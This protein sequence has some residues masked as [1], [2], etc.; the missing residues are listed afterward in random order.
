MITVTKPRYYDSFRCLAS[1]CP[2]S[3]C[4][5]WAVAVDP[6]A[7]AL[8][9]SLPGALG[10]ALRRYLKEEDGDTV[11]SLR[12]DG[13][14][15]MWRDDGLCRIQAEQGEA[16]LCDTCRNFPRLTHD[17]GSFLERDL[18]LSCPEAARLILLGEDEAVTGEEAARTEPDYD[19]EA[20]ALLLDSREKALALLRE[21]RYSVGEALAILLLYG[22][23]V[24][25]ALDGGEE[26]LLE[27]E[28]EREIA[29]KVAKKGKMDEILSFF[30]NLELLT[31]R[32]P[33]RLKAPVPGPWT[34]G[35]RAIARYFVRRYW[36]QAVSD[37]DLYSRVKLTVVSCLVLKHLGG[38][39]AE[40]A[41][42][43]SK[44]IENNA[45]NVDALLD[46]AYTES[47]F[48]DTALLGLLT[49]FAEGE[50]SL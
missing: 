16:A 14:C 27:P 47:C 45:S 3:C 49:N 2:D 4:H 46:G 29:K 5:E 40:T 21:P 35:H 37:L 44:E 22:S 26:A 31:D 32:W 42:L 34:E 13:R 17:Y 15:P 18:E 41:Q 11:L 28:K 8:Y 25:N 36:L 12:P 7:E 48:A 10:E 50:T 33:R 20:M 19:E 38:D 1:G 30:E 39:L 24:Q 9:R 43:Y 23:R 6:K